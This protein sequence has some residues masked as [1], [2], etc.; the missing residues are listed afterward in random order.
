MYSPDKLGDIT[1]TQ[2]V[3]P[4]NM[5]E[6]HAALEASQVTVMAVTPKVPGYTSKFQDLTSIVEKS[7]GEHFLFSSVIS[8]EANL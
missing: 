8:T 6:V 7:N 1:A 5:A 2:G 3:L 4:P